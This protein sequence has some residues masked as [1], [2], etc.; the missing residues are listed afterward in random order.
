MG[1]LAAV[2]GFSAASAFMMWWAL[3]AGMSWWSFALIIGLFY[4]IAIGASRLVAAAGV[5]YVGTGIFPRE[6]ILRTV[7]A[8]AL[9]PASLT[10]YSYLY[11]IYM[12]DA[13]NLAMPQM[14]TSF[15]LGRV[16]R[17]RG[18]SLTKA[19]AL[20]VV[21]VVV[22][23]LA[24]LLKLVHTYGAS[25]AQSMWGWPFSSFSERAFGELETSLQSPE[26]ADNWLRAA[27]AIGAA[28]TLLLTWL[29]AAFVWWPVSPVGFLI[30]TSWPMRMLIW[31]N[32]FVG[33]ML[34]R[35][36]V[37]FGGLALFRRLRPAFLGLVL[38]DVFARA[39]L[40][41]LAAALGVESGSWASA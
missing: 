23:G 33:W 36:V 12:S 41:A 37:R 19:S 21:I 1:P 6:A 34:N 2:L 5:I 17:L 28:T 24:A 27:T 10:M 32:V 31:A 8:A 13:M 22:V 25:G 18:P 4:A 7:G 29:R 39:A 30:A 11:I 3:R 38:G 9:G 40:A 20:A 15:K 35:L 26:P 16:G 14:M